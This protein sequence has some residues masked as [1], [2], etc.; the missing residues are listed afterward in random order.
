MGKSNFVPVVETGVLG[1]AEATETQARGMN[2]TPIEYTLGCA[3]YVPAQYA[4]E[5]PSA[6]EGFSNSKR[7]FALEMSLQGDKLVPTGNLTAIKLSAI[8]QTYLGEVTE[9]EAPKIKCELNDSGAYRPIR[10]EAQYFRA[11]PGAKGLICEG[12]NPKMRYGMI[13]WA[14][15]Q[16]QG[17]VPKFDADD[18]INHTMIVDDDNILS[19]DKQNIILWKTESAVNRKINLKL[20]DILPENTPHLDELVVD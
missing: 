7:V 19:L 16:I 20:Q 10:G 4:H 5:V 3:Y 15:R 2:A 1:R 12:R 9:E 13:Y 14:D 11:V 18:T 17:Y 8:N 6:Q